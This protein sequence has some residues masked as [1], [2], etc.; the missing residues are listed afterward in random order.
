MLKKYLKSKARW[1][2]SDIP[3]DVEILS[4]SRLALSKFIIKLIFFNYYFIVTILNYIKFS[5][6]TIF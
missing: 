6:L 5:I 1:L 3:Q 2:Q 4:V